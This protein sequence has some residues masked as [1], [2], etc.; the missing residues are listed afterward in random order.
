[1]NNIASTGFQFATRG[2]NNQR[3]EVREIKGVMKTRGKRPKEEES[4]EIED[5]ED[6]LEEDKD[7]DE[8]VSGDQQAEDMRCVSVRPEK[9]KTILLKN[10]FR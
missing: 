8:K 7:D 6:I 10:A 5:V 2:V 4:S 3:E 1:M 9:R